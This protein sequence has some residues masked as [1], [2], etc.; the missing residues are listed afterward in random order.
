MKE[1]GQNVDWC[2]CTWIDPQKM[3]ADTYTEVVT[4]VSLVVK[5]TKKK[6]RKKEK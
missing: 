2:A 1:G 6:G 4:M 3:L 5:T